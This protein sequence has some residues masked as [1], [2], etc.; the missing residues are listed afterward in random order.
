MSDWSW[1]PAQQAIDEL[2][3]EFERFC[4]SLPIKPDTTNST[5]M[6]MRLS[7]IAPTEL[8]DF[9]GSGPARL[10]ARYHLPPSFANTPTSR[11]KVRLE[12]TLARGSV[13]ARLRRDPAYVRVGHSKRYPGFSYALC[14][15]QPGPRKGGG[16]EKR[17]SERVDHA[18]N[19]WRFFL[20][21]H[22][23]F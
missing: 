3:R 19:F 23:R 14:R 15:D 18:T 21:R 4:N 1:I 16:V 9:S 10:T 5:I 7:R 2:E 22:I 13:S 11:R 17:K 12:I 8:H 20:Y 6:T